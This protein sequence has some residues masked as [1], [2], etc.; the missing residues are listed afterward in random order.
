MKLTFGSVYIRMVITFLTNQKYSKN[1]KYLTALFL[2]PL[3]KVAS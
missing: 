3:A 1:Y 2:P